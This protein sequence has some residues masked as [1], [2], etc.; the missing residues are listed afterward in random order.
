MFKY[1]VI[2]LVFVG[3]LFILVVNVVQWYMFM[4]YGDVNLL[5]KIVY[6]F[7]EDIK[8]GI[9]GD[10]EVMVY[11][12]VFLVKYLEILRV[13]CIGQV[14]FGEIFIGIMGNIY[15]VFKYDNILFLVI[16]FD[17]VCKLWEVVKLEIEK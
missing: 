7:V 16:N 5:I 10:I 11:F 1:F 17:D 3:V 9:E 8:F 4:L 13:V 6:E 15:L 14:Q 2:V 12:G